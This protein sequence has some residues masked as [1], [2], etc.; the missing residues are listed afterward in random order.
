MNK[1]VIT[2]QAIVSFGFFESSFVEEFIG[3]IRPNKE[4]EE[5]KL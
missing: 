3:S 4:Q 5:L 1:S 2:T